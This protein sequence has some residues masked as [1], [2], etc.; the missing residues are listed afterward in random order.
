MPWTEDDATAHT[1]KAT[2]PRL[3]A[4]WAHVANGAK[5]R[6]ESDASAIRIAN[7][8]V[9]RVPNKPERHEPHRWM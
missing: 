9:E 1:H 4:M 5:R 7:A 2:T 8:A 3:R 6:G